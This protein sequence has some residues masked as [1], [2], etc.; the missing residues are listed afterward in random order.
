MRPGGVP[1]ASIVEDPEAASPDL[2]MSRWVSGQTGYSK[3]F[4]CY[5]H[6]CYLVPPVFARSHLQGDGFQPTSM[7]NE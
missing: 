2:V 1:S 4:S 6:A 7:S 5:G 3:A